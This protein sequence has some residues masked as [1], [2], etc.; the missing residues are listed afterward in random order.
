MAFANTYVSNPTIEMKLI[1]CQNVFR[2]TSKQIEIRFNWISNSVRQLFANN[3]PR[4]GYSYPL[5]AMLI[6]RCVHGRRVL[7]H[8][9]EL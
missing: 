6:N 1:P 8:I 5:C 2:Q 4:F 9:R 3:T 7:C